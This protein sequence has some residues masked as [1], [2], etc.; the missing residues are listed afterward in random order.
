MKTEIPGWL[1]MA[2]GISFFSDL[3]STTQGSDAKPLPALKLYS[4]FYFPVRWIISVLKRHTEPYYFHFCWKWSIVF[5]YKVTHDT[6]IK[7]SLYFQLRIG[8]R[9]KILSGKWAVIYGLVPLEKRVLNPF[10]ALY[11][12]DHPAAPGPEHAPDPFTS[13]LR[14]D[15]W[16]KIGVGSS[17]SSETLTAEWRWWTPEVFREKKTQRCLLIS[18]PFSLHPPHFTVLS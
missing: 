1:H 15:W 7:C 2:F 6:V 10:Y 18:C 9:S 5:W 17:R 11:H 14:W 13:R 12:T 3:S 16:L 4:N 8:A